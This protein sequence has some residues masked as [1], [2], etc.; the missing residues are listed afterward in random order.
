M[1]QQVS[2]LLPSLCMAGAHTHPELN[3]LKQMSDMMVCFDKGEP[4]VVGE[5]NIGTKLNTQTEFILPLCL[6]FN[7]IS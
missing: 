2:I 4:N 5:N 1:L 7:Y 6:C 3:C